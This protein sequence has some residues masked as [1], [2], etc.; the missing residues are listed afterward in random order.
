MGNCKRVLFPFFF[1]I[2]VNIQ[3]TR[4]SADFLQ[5]LKMT[6]SRTF[7]FVPCNQRSKKIKVIGMNPKVSS[8]ISHGDS[9]FFSVIHARDMTKKRLSLFLYQT[10][11]LPLFF[12]L[13]IWHSLCWQCTG[14]LSHMGSIT[15]FLS[16]DFFEAH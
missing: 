3:G 16:I 4:Y 10:Q 11:N 15:A 12:S 9:A 2:R 1:F 13:Y 14:L 6:V 7:F 5:N 8:P